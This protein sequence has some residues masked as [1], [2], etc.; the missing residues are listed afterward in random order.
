MELKIPQ[1][2][3]VDFQ[4]FCVLYGTESLYFM[5]FINNAI[6]RFVILGAIQILSTHSECLLY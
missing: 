2:T 3:I 1:T 6:R 5:E 4:Q